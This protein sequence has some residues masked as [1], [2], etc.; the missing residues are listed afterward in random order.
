LSLLSL[1]QHP[2]SA[3]FCRLGIC[4]A[5][6]RG[7]RKAAVAVFADY[8]GTVHGGALACDTTETIRGRGQFNAAC[9]FGSAVLTPKNSNFSIVGRHGS[10]GHGWQRQAAPAV[11]LELLAVRVLTVKLMEAEAEAEA[12]AV[13]RALTE[14]TAAVSS[15]PA[16]AA[17]GAVGARA[18]RLA[19]LQRTTAAMAL[20]VD[21]AKVAAVAAVAATAS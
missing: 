20:P 11:D 10:N 15:L 6:A 4:R 8:L 19:L 3:R 5:F 1:Y 18:E 16:Q 17:R 14:V 21:L 7:T 2:R 12:V 13:A 9:V